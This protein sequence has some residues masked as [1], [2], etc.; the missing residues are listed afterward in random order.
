MLGQR[1]GK[2]KKGGMFRLTRWSDRTGQEVVVNEP[3]QAGGNRISLQ[4]RSI[5]LKNIC[6]I[7]S[8]L[9]KISIYSNKKLTFE[10]HRRSQQI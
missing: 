1:M 2:S 7:F 8:V 10:S 6:D 4:Y 5:L 9:P 3:D